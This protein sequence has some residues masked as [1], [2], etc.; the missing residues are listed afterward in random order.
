MGSRT[1]DLVT[2]VQAA[3]S[4]DLDALR[5]YA[6]ANIP[7]FPVFSSNF[8]VSQV[9]ILPSVYKDIYL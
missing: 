5:R 4:L 6:A 2:Q 8:S 3:H 7:G 9:L 1:A